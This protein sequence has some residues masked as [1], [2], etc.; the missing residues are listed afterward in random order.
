METLIAATTNAASSAEFV[1]NEDRPTFVALGAYAAGED[2]TMQVW[3]GTAW[4]DVIIEGTTQV[5]DEQNTVL[6]VYGRGTY[7]FN[8]DATASAAG[9]IVTGV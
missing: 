4:V 5:L 2:A 9:V 1:V 8:K 7:R 6:T 3:N